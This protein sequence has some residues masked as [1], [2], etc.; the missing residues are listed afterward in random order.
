MAK[1]RTGKTDDRLKRR[2]PNKEPRKYI[3]IVVEGQ[4][5][6]YNY[7]QALKADL[8]LATAQIEVVPGC[9]GSPAFVVEE[10]RKLQQQKQ[11]DVVFCVFDWDGKTEAYQQ[12]VKQVKKY[13]FESAA[14][15]PCFEFWFLLHYRYTSGGFEGC[16]R[17]ISELEKSMGAKY[18]KN[19]KMY[20]Q[21]KPKLDTAI[22]NAKKLEA[23]CEQ[24]L[25]SNNFHNP[26]TQV[27]QLV[28][29][30]RNQ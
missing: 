20:Q 23:D 25:K 1:K 30:M 17:V 16:D 3:L 26:Y 7:F 11:P 18:E 29:L 14:S 27:Y 12:A 28:E 22:A 9:G 8:R 24:E 13:K 10:A 21:L 19:L 6:E 4:E 2:S 15:I 5:T